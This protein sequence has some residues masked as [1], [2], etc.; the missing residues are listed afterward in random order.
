MAVTVSFGERAM[1][2][3][4]HCPVEFHGSAWARWW[5]W[6]S[7]VFNILWHFMCGIGIGTRYPCTH[8]SGSCQVDASRS[9]KAWMFARGHLWGQHGHSGRGD[10]VEGWYS[11]AVVPHGLKFEVQWN[12][13]YTKQYH[14][15][16]WSLT[17]LE[18]ADFLLSTCDVT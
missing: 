10:W 11:V 5:Y 16:L 6:H 8:C 9:V 18:L 13:C 17:V 4:C 15:C 1:R 14:D 12:Y 7:I 2:V 3:R